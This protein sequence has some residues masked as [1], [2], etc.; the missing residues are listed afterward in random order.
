MATSHVIVVQDMCDYSLSV[1]ELKRVSNNRER[2]QHQF[3]CTTVPPPPHRSGTGVLKALANVHLT[4]HR[5]PAA[6]PQR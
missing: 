2:H 3:T 4:H 6:A 5:T 1:K